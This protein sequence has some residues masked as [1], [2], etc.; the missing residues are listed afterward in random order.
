ML[1]SPS[2]KIHLFG[3]SGHLVNF[4]HYLFK[5]F[6]RTRPYSLL[7]FLWCG[8]LVC[9]PNYYA[10]P[11][12]HIE[13]TNIWTCQVRLLV[14]P[15]MY[16]QVDTCVTKSSCFEWSIS[17]IEMVWI[18]FHSRTTS[19]FF[20]CILGEHQR[21]FRRAILFT[22]AMR[23]VKYLQGLRDN[24][25]YKIRHASHK[26]E[27]THTHTQTTNVHIRSRTLCICI[28]VKMAL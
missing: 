11:K 4:P 20:S 16:E 7:S 25:F 19:M 23:D 13:Y 14:F 10:C 6:Q 26:P 9:G 17:Y 18:H 5:R 24:I 28:Y 22:V 27:Y 15:S 21:L 1:Y 2:W 12:K 8:F 3:I